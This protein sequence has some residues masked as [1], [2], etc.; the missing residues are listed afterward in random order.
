MND[1]F[2]FNDT[3]K[4]SFSGELSKTLGADSLYDVNEHAVDITDKL[5]N[6]SC[7]YTRRLVNSNRLVYGRFECRCLIRRARR[8]GAVIDATNF[9]G[10]TSNKMALVCISGL[11]MFICRCWTDKFYRDGYFILLQMEGGILSHLLL[12]S[13]ARRRNGV[14]LMKFDQTHSLSQIIISKAC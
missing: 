10:T 8:T 7:P 3:S 11:S 12:W 14:V 5:T 9:L 1:D 6:F 13:H 2:D 4:S